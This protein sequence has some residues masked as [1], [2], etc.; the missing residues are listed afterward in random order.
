MT[1]A[2]SDLVL[3]IKAINDKIVHAKVFSRDDENLLPRL[4]AERERAK[5]TLEE[6]FFR[7]WRTPTKH[8]EYLVLRVFPASIYDDFCAY[9]AATGNEAAQLELIYSTAKG[10]LLKLDF[11]VYSPD[12]DDRETRHLGVASCNAFLRSIDNLGALQNAVPDPTETQRWTDLWTLL[13]KIRAWDSDT[14]EKR[15][16]ENLCGFVSTFG[17]GREFQSRKMAKEMMK[18][19]PDKVR[20]RANSQARQPR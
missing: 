18:L 10:L 15:M 1:Y 9:G 5:S 16:L 20:G 13:E 4:E 7:A 14:V 19:H 17:W 6:V 11:G 12:H 3:S 2:L 8:R